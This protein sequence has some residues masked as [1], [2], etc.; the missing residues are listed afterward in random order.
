MHTVAAACAWHIESRARIHARTYNAFLAITVGLQVWSFK[1]EGLRLRQNGRRVARDQDII[2]VIR[3]S[4]RFRD[5]RTNFKLNLKRVSSVGPI[6]PKLATL[7][8]I[9]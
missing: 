6:T 8:P 3:D 4:S 1:D 7:N 5:S 9:K 2:R